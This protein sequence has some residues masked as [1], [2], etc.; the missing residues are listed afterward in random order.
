MPKITRPSGLTIS[1]PATY[2]V[3]TPETDPTMHPIEALRM[4]R[5]SAAELRSE[6]AR[7]PE[8]A[9][10][11]FEESALLEALE[12][13][14]MQ[15]VDSIAL[16]PKLDPTPVTAIRHRSGGISE[17]QGVRFKQNILPGEDAVLLVEQD[18]IYSWVFAE[19]EEDIPLP[20]V[21]RS[22][23]NNLHTRTRS[24]SFIQ[25]TERHRN[26]LNG[27]DSSAI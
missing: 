5:R 6:R 11:Q 23:L 7:M 16:Q 19:K 10:P 18:G 4:R 24:I 12:N 14:D 25:P 26:R 2:T 20:A 9:E 22:T 13:Q 21:R 27:V 3:S 8:G 17:T 15:L 1:L